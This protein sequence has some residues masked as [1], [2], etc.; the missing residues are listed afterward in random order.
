[1][2]GSLLTPLF[3]HPFFTFVFCEKSLTFM[4]TLAENFVLL[5]FNYFFFNIITSIWLTVVREEFG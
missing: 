4:V 2:F 1:M 5:R 3:F